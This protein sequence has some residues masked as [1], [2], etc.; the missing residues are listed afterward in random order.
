[1]TYVTVRQHIEPKQITWEDVLF[2]KITEFDFI[3][4]NSKCTGT[5]TRKYDNV[6]D[7]FIKSINVDEMIAKLE[8]FNARHE[9]LFN[10]KKET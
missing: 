5:I 10:A 4:Q 6:D 3:N 8:M 1:M 2:E 9:N 7:R